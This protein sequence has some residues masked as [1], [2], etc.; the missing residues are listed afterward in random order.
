MRTSRA[1]R[2]EARHFFT[3]N[4]AGVVSLSALDDIS[5]YEL[6]R[7][8]TGMLGLAPGTEAKIMSSVNSLVEVDD[9]EGLL[10]FYQ[11]PGAWTPPLR[12]RSKTRPAE[13][14]LRELFLPIV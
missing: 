4:I 14:R 13:L 9:F 8:L 12:A 11:E 10:W 6:R 3:D 1:R 2:F 7:A 5:V